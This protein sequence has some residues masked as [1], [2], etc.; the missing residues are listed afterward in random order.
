MTVGCPICGHETK[1]VSNLFCEAYGRLR[2]P[3]VELHHYE[4]V[5]CGHGVLRHDL[6]LDQLYSVAMATPM[7]HGRDARLAFIT[8]HLD[9]GCVSGSVIE[10]GGGPGE[11]A[12]QTRCAAKKDRAYVVDFV[13]RVAFPNLDFIEVDLNRDAKRLV[14]FFDVEAANLFL[15]SHV[16]EHLRDPRALMSELQKFRNSFVFIEVPDFGSRHTPATLQWQ[17]NGLEHEQYFNDASLIQ[18]LH[19][20]GF[21]V[22]A[23]ETQTA[24]DMTVIRAICSPRRASAAGITQHNVLYGVIAERLRDQILSQPVDRELWVWGLSPYM[25]EALTKS[26]EARGRIRGIV[27]NRYPGTTFA[28]LDVFK[29]PGPSPDGRPLVLCGSTY[30]VVQSAFRA[31]AQNLWPNAEF[32]TAPL[33]D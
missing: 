11:L 32:V 4:C 24:P 19:G 9:L 29:E 13:S 16:L 28:G 18:L 22:L 8:S 7:D 27:D 5:D 1:E 23:F 17:M 15:M 3:G 2:F 10:I 26:D 20:A 14:D 33:D 25:A 12:H 30:A 21:Q 31:K 6:P